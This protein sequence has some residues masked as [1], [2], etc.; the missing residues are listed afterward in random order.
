[1]NELKSGLK[2]SGGAIAVN[3][4]LAIIKIT[5]GLI[6]NSYALIADGIES[7]MDVF[8]S[9]VVWG[10][11]QISQKPPDEDHPYGH[12]KAESMAGIVV[13][14]SLIS[15]AV[16]IAVQSIRGLSAPH[17]TPAWYTLVILALVILV[18]ETLFHKMTQVGQDLGSSSLKTD[19]WHQHSDALTS[20]AAFIG[21]SIALI[22]GERFA[23]ADD[24]AALLACG[25]IL[26]NGIHLLLPAVD[27]IMDRAAPE[28]FE[29]QVRRIA[30]GVG[31]VVS[32]EKCRIRK[33]GLVYLLD[34]H[35]TV[36]GGISV[37]EGHQIG[38]QV[39]DRL[40]S[41]GLNILDVDVHL[42]PDDLRAE[43]GGQAGGSEGGGEASTK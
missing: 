11:L 20:G 18:K 37:R 12:G 17:Q 21:I 14:L 5:T 8:S 2:V 1:M 38:H 29:E 15:A 28:E 22:G 35:V 7:T 43:P 23:S 40:L 41:A 34:I 32:I 6:G 24:W 10:G 16:I 36:P 19:A 25:L 3:V 13:A 42:E 26:Y 9:L 31:G 4:V 39:K 27:E 30:A 33:S